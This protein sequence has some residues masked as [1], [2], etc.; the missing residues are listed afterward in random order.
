MSAPRVEFHAGHRADEEPRVLH[1][2]GGPVAV[3]AI[4]ERWV[5]PGRRGFLVRG[6]DGGCYRLVGSGD[7]WRVDKTRSATDG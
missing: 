2:A 5:E 3:V 4:L 6:D 1:L 7:G